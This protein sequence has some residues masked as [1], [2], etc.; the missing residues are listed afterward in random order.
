MRHCNIQEGS[1]RLHA[2]PT[3]IEIA[4][5]SCVQIVSDASITDSE[6]V[7][8]DF[9]LNCEH[10]FQAALSSVP[11]TLAVNWPEPLKH[12][13]LPSAYK[14]D[15]VQGNGQLTLKTDKPMKGVH[16]HAHVQPETV[17]WGDN[18]FDLVPNEPHTIEALNLGVN[19]FVEI[20]YYGGEWVPCEFTWQKEGELLFSPEL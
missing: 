13:R 20:T 14:V 2:Q 11:L 5:N 12:I 17:Q 6:I 15:F 19:D 3:P 18:G 9:F 7:V 1:L 10:P 4:P 16:L 8:A